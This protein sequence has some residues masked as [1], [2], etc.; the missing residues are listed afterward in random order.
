M[1]FRSNLD[2]SPAEK[3]PENLPHRPMVGDLIESAHAWRT[4]S[5][6]RILR[7]QVVR[8]TWKLLGTNNWEWTMEIELHLP[9]NSWKSVQQF[10]DWYDFVQG[11]ISLETYQRRSQSND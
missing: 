3:W 7:L 10:I 2:L 6:I 11:K 1:N 8:V 5:G 4:S 9:P